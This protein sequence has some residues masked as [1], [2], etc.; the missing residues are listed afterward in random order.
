MSRL[1]IGFVPFERF[2]QS[3]PAYRASGDRRSIERERLEASVK[4]MSAKFDEIE[5]LLTRLRAA[6]KAASNEN[7][8]A[9]HVIAG[10][11]KAGLLSN[12]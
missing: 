7:G 9:N 8:V 6:P 5:I 3:S 4:R 10:L 1:E 2:C 12:R 11:S